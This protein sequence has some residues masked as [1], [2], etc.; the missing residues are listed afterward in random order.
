MEGS[1]L[2]IS[3]LR[4]EFGRQ[5]ERFKAFQHSLQEKICQAHGEI[6]HT[7]RLLES[8]KKSKECANQEIGMLGHEI[9]NE[10]KAHQDL[11]EEMRKGKMI[12]DNLREKLNEE[13]V[14]LELCA[15]ENQLILRTLQIDI[16]PASIS[17]PIPKKT[18]PGK[19]NSEAP[20]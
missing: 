2:E 6:I 5:N 20:R 16:T 17:V 13:I 10:E 14:A 4:T 1:V 18:S 8:I 9:D 15:Y 7:K 12:L 3:T 11:R 19:I